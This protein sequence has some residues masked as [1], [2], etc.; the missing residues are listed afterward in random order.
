MFLYGTLFIFVIWQ[1]LS[2]CLGE[3]T[4]PSPI[5]TIRLAFEYLGQAYTYQCLGYSLLRMLL[6][7]AIAFG[8]AFLLGIIVND[9]E[10][11]YQFF[12]PTMTFFKAIPTA[13]L[14]FIFIVITTAQEA[15][16]LVVALIAIP[17]LYE[18]IVGGLKNTEKD[19][20]ESAEVDGAKK[21]KRVFKVRLPMAIPYIIIGMVSA[22][23]LSFKIE[24]MAEVITG[25]TENG[26][27]SLIKGAMGSSIDMTPVFAYSFIAVVLMLVITLVAYIITQ[28]LKKKQIID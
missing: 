11:L 9:S 2:L 19:I 27:G 7:F 21:F 3:L 20:L 16:I 23:S 24:I 17:I 13:A 1:I 28:H 5:S 12:T 6:G 18:A 10:K 22:F 25:S 4:V 8:I 15:P 26:I 14:V